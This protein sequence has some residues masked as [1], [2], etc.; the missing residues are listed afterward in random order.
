M[1]ARWECQGRG[2]KRKAGGKTG[3]K[4]EDKREGS[5]EKRH[6]KLYQQTPGKF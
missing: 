3:K 1:L 2:E 4:W 6:R 5:G